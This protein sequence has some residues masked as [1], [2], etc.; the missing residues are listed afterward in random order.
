MVQTAM[1][2]GVTAIL[3]LGLGGA[4]S[5]A[6]TDGMI[7]LGP[8]IVFIAGAPVLFSV[9]VGSLA[10]IFM[11]PDVPYD[12]AQIDKALDNVNQALAAYN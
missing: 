5:A 9:F 6:S 4:C 1:V 8:A 11:Q 10:A 12:V 2:V 3:G 7:D